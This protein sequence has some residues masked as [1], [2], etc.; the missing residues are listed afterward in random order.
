MCTRHA[1]P[2]IDSPTSLSWVFPS[3]KHVTNPPQS[4]HIPIAQAAFPSSSASNPV[5]HSRCCPRTISPPQSPRGML[6]RGLQ[7]GRGPHLVAGLSV[8]LASM[9]SPPPFDLRTP[10]RRAT[11][12]R[13]RG[14]RGTEVGSVGV[15]AALLRAVHRRAQPGPEGPRLSHHGSLLD[16][17]AL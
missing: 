1:H 2:V 13:G 12:G 3:S 17:A 15:L 7:D 5:S 16:P 10:S 8:S 14:S 6:P 11:A 4:P 9:F